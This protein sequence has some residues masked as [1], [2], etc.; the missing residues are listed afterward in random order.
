MREGLVPVASRSHTQSLGAP[1]YGGELSGAVQPPTNQFERPLAAIRRYRW[2]I[3]SMVLVFGAGG[4]AAS[5]LVTPQYEARATIW[6][7]SESPELRATGPIRSGELLRSGSWI[8]LLRSY[9][10]V[11]A[12]V[13]KLALYLEPADPA[14][15]PLF[16][17]FTLGERFIPGMYE[18]QID[19]GKKTW[20][21]RAK[22]AKSS[23]GESGTAAEQGA[24]ADSVGRTFGF[25]W[26]LAPGAFEGSG[27]Q[28]VPFSVSTPRETS[29]RLGERLN[30]R[31]IQGSNFLWLTYT[32]PDARLSAV[33]LNTWIEEFV[34]VAAE[35]KRRHM[36]EFA[37]ILE[38]QLQYA[39]KATQDAEAALQNFRVNAITLPTEGGPVAA[40][41]LERER[42]P[43]LLSYFEQKI[44]YDN[45]RHDREA[46]EQNMASASR[47][48]VPYEGLLL[49][50]SVAQS[51]GAE[52][53]REAFRNRYQLRARLAAER[54]NFTDEYVTVKELK[55]LLEVLETRTIPQLANELLAQMREREADYRRRIESA[56]RE[57]QAIPPRT[58]EERRLNRAVVVSEGLYTNL[59]ARFAEAKLAEA[60]ATPDISVLD[61]AVVPQTPTKN[62]A[63]MIILIAVV[64]GLGA[65]AGLAIL[66]DKIDGKF[67]YADQAVSELGLVIAGAVPRIPR[68]GT[69][70]SKPEQ[71]VQ[72]VESF[73][74]LRMHVTHSMR[75]ERL[76]LAVTSAAPGDGK[77]LISANL[78]L[79]CAE[80]GMRTILIDGDTRRGALHKTF[81]LSAKGGLTEYLVGALHESQLV[82]DTGHANLDFISCGQR[83]RT[84]P[85]RL[86]SPKLKALIDQLA[87]EYDVVIIDTPPLAAGIDA[88]AISAA[89]GNVLMVLRMGH[90][91]R[92][93]ASAKLAVLDHLPVDILGSVLNE[94]PGWGEFRY[95]S[96]PAG[97][98]IDE[99]ASTR[100]LTEVAS[101]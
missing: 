22:Q 45:L 40:G 101:G 21:L 88:Y 16:A 79:S 24:A 97:Y 41:V 56:S 64:A 58:I 92:R 62:T 77:S 53:L 95:Y 28:T 49:I 8:E 38:G 99:S 12:V 33:T 52:G 74:T 86:A 50:P 36:V 100:G 51:P 68:N 71:V 87:Q 81:G 19:R 39:A 78:A 7:A 27:V 5:K 20:A 15:R 55:A 44:E 23:T 47:N 43:A 4:V 25:K 90:T 10:I 96:Y 18:L 57:L 42:D 83:D 30:P 91:E 34:G 84:S 3:V 65:A 89:T 9:K 72:F 93:L 85:E 61:T 63:A 26:V 94:V 67:R 31:L 46:M 13:R 69:S 11:D 14:H 75:G 32:D 66:L 2:L 76:R 48:S 80:A 17:G 73:R 54:Q 70:A 98:S 29:I 35:L 60:S 37:N 82:R 1:V 6:I 59:R